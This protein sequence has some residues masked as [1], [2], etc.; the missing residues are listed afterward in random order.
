[1][2]FNYILCVYSSK[3]GESLQINKKLTAIERVGL[4]GATSFSRTTLNTMT[5][6]R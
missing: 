5:L 6:S 4:F 1:M 2:Q 3:Q